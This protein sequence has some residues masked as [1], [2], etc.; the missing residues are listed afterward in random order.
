MTRKNQ[1]FSKIIRTLLLCLLILVLLY[2]PFLSSTIQTNFVLTMSFVYFYLPI[3]FLLT[4]CTVICT[5][6][7]V[8]RLCKEKERLLSKPCKGILLISLFLSAFYLVFA[9]MILC[10]SASNEINAFQD[11]FSLK[12]VISEETDLED[13]TVHI[14][15]KW[16]NTVYIK[17]ETTVNWERFTC[18]DKEIRDQCPPVAVAY[19]VELM[20]NAPSIYKAFIFNMEKEWFVIS[21]QDASFTDDEDITSFDYDGV[22]FTAYYDKYVDFQTERLFFLAE[23]ENSLVRFSIT[24]EDANEVLQLDIDSILLQTCQML[25]SDKE[26]VPSNYP[27]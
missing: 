3:C 19:E 21:V 11:A 7:V 16:G 14:G 27:R 8:Y 20:Q 1:K 17:G 23:Y 6:N 24:L 2:A 9:P 26:A 12:Q 13:L 25:R 15:K 10:P 5:V 4:V 22:H 18:V